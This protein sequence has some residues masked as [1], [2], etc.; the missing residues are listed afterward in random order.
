M[1]Y[2]SSSNLKM[3]LY[4]LLTWVRIP[5]DMK[6]FSLYMVYYSQESFNI[7]LPKA[8]YGQSHV[9]RDTN[10]NDYDTHDS[11]TRNKTIDYWDNAV[12]MQSRTFLIPRS[13]QLYMH[14]SFWHSS[15]VTPRPFTCGVFRWL[16]TDFSF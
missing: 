11:L 14:W 7:N 15:G 10:I 3:W 2:S 6:F 12:H 13:C 1:M 4:K 8:Q 16:D 9:D 5:L